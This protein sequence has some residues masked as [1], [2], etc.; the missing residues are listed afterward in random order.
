MIGNEETVLMR[1]RWALAAGVAASLLTVA[2]C[3]RET[4][5][6]VEAMAADDSAVD[7]ASTDTTVDGGA[8]AGSTSSNSAEASGSSEMAS[9]TMDDAQTSPTTP[10]TGTAAPMT[11]RE[12]VEMTRE[13]L[14]P[15]G[16]SSGPTAPRPQ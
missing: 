2:A 13:T 14:S 15:A 7:A 11:T 8:E 6:D 10:M 4:E 12:Q 1:S 5:A 3:N 9:E 16:A